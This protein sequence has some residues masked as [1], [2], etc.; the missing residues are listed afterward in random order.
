[1]I[2]VIMSTP[3]EIRNFIINLKVRG[4]SSLTL[5]EFEHLCNASLSQLPNA[6]DTRGK[7]CSFC[8]W[9]IG[10][11]CKTCPNCL[12]SVAIM[13]SQV[14]FEDGANDCTG[15]CALDLSNKIYHE[16]SCN[17]RFCCA[18][19]KNRV[20]S[21]YRTCCMC[22]DVQIPEEILQKYNS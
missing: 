5:S 4:L 3:R 8:K 16:L 9:K 18:C 6:S 20:S 22:D 1:M 21:G 13:N 2:V 15:E 17:H 12:K 10:N 14:V 19:M 11:A 7:E